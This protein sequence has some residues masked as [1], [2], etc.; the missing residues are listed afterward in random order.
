MAPHVNQDTFPENPSGDRF[1][2]FAKLGLGAYAK[3]E[4][5]QEGD[6]PRMLRSNLH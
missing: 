2:D 4:G 3:A 5:N 6:V 1:M